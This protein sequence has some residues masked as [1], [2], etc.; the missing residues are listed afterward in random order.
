MHPIT[1]LQHSRTAAPMQ[2]GAT[3][4]LT[5]DED[6]D[7]EVATLERLLR[8]ICDANWSTATPPP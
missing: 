2:A 4:H 7:D 3:D 5:V 8:K 1:D 6:P